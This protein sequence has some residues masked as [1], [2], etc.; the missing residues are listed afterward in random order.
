MAESDTEFWLHTRREVTIVDLV[1]ACG[2]SEGELRELVDYGALHPR[3]GEGGEWQFGAEC[4]VRLRTAVRLRQDLEL[5]L[6]AVALVLSYLE[7]IDALE[8]RVRDLSARLP[9]SR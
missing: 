7:R 5:E 9:R 2:L 4:L 1:E 8:A 6:P 3:G